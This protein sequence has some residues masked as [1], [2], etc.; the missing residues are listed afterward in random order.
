[1]HEQVRL[2]RL[3]IDDCDLLVAVPRQRRL[4]LRGT[5]ELLG[6][7]G[8]RLARLRRAS[9]RDD[10]EGQAQRAGR[11]P[12]VV[13]AAVDAVALDADA[14]KPLQELIREDADAVLPAGRTVLA[15]QSERGW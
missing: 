11:R 4:R 7:G 1:A 9:R 8:V 3:A 12:G 6:E 14:A 5:G 10:E 2:E 15:V 13:A